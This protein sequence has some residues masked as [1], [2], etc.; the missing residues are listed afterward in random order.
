MILGVSIH[1]FGK[2]K[3]SKDEDTSVRMFQES[4]SACSKHQHF[5]CSLDFGSE[6]FPRSM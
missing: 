5:H 6:Q 4:E 1:R 3:S 2:Q